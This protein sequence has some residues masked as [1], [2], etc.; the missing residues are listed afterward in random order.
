MQDTDIIIAIAGEDIK[1]GDCLYT[2]MEKESPII[3]KLGNL[4]NVNRQK[5]IGLED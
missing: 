5:L 3:Y 2:K 1:K 4:K